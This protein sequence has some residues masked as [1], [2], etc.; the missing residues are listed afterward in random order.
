MLDFIGWFGSILLAICGVPLALQSIKDG[1]SHGINWYFLLI[2]LLGEILVLIY[3]LPKFDWPLIFNYAG[4][5]VLISIVCWYK[6]Y[7]RNK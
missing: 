4:N 6:L 7:P 3:V 1:H 2:W 5:I